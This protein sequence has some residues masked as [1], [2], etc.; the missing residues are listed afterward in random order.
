MKLI[1]RKP[2][3]SIESFDDVDYIELPDFTILTGINGA[4]KT[5]LLEAINFEERGA[6]HIEV[7]D[8]SEE[9]IEPMHLYKMSLDTDR[10]FK[11]YSFPELVD[12]QHTLFEKFS[13]LRER[14]SNDDDLISLLEKN[15]EPYASISSS[16]REQSYSIY[17]PF[18]EIVEQIANFFNIELIN[19]EEKHFL[20][21]FPIGAFINNRNVF[22]N[23]FSLLF[24][25]WQFNYIENSKRKRDSSTDFL[26]N[27]NFETYL[28]VKPWVEINKMLRNFGSDH[29][30]TYPGLNLQN[31]KESFKAELK[32][33]ISGDI[34][35]LGHLSSGEK[36]LMSLFMALYNKTDT[37]FSS[38]K[39]KV[40]L[41]DEADASLHPSVTKRFIDTIRDVFINKYNM[42][43][44]LATHNISTVANASEDSIYVMNRKGDKKRRIEK[45]S[46]SEAIRVLSNGFAT[47]EQGIELFDQISNKKLVIITEGNNARY[48]NKATELLAN[49]YKDD[50]DVITDAENIT[51]HSQLAILF[52]FFCAVPHKAKV[53]FVWDGDVPRHKSKTAKENTYPFVFEKN[54]SNNIAKKGIENLFSESLF[55]DY[56]AV[57]EKSNGRIIEDFDGDRKKDFLKFILSRNNKDDF[58]NF[59]PLIEFIVNILKED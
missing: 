26:H 13:E 41:L 10:D 47:L 30:I 48:I 3:K 31:E 12:M 56:K 53:V 36:T 27:E 7:F 49:K 35:Q 32:D 23:D 28:G 54:N 29:E 5:H 52:A 4:G 25:G 39:P 14:I 9:K 16:R 59:I 1:L 44:I 43:V 2:Y 57:T 8:D 55:T 15:S 38:S 18:R 21:F 42:K 45:Q 40:L 17:T 24:K 50:L 37:Y 11:E 6:K 58:E 19:L 20:G 33:K 34:V 46:R 51:S 22:Y